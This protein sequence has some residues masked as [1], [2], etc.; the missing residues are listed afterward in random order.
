MALA[1]LA[2]EP[3]GSSAGG[4]FPKFTAARTVAGEPAH[5]IV[6]FSGTDD[7]PPVRRWADLLN[8][9]AARRRDRGRVSRIS[10]APATIHRFAQRT[11]L[12]VRR[13]DR[14]GRHGRGPAC[15]IGSIDAALLGIADP[16]WDRAAVALLAARLIDDATR[17]NI[18]LLFHFGTLIGN[19]DMHGGNLVMRP[20]EGKLELAPAFDMLPM[21][22]APSRGGEVPER[23]YA[24]TLPLPEAVECWHRAAGAALTFWLR[25][26]EAADLS[27]DFRRIA[28]EN[29]AELARVAALV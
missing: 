1:T 11:F 13:F 27:A 20:N 26:G 17:R 16:R 6:K 2:G 4:E 21:L 9:E 19:T 25:C 23:R 12:E 7:T 22:Y 3:P 14:V 10:A 28:H 18:E 8:C 5:V 29:H 24:P 15:T